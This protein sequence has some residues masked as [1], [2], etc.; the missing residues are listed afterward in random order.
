M[1]SQ[2]S[3]TER[4]MSE[5]FAKAQIGDHVKVWGVG[6][7]HMR[8]VGIVEEVYPDGSASIN[9]GKQMGVLDLDDFG[10]ANPNSWRISNFWRDSRKPYSAERDSKD[11][12]PGNA[13]RLRE[14]GGWRRGNGVGL[15]ASRCEYYA[16]GQGW[17]CVARFGEPV[18]RP[19]RGHLR[20]T[21][22]EVLEDPRPLGNRPW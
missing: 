8:F 13:R 6:P 1:K 2:T 15:G 5:A 9:L 3:K 10:E 4:S 18:L 14:S 22:S 21:R 11:T 16:D 7:D 19:G 12:E 20:G 17:H